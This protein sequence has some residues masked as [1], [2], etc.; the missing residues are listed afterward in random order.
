MKNDNVNSVFYNILI[1]SLIFSLHVEDDL[2]SYFN[3]YDKNKYFDI[4]QNFGIYRKTRK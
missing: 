3:N 4:I 1:N 2:N